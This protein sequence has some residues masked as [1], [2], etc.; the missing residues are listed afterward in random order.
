MKFEPEILKF[1]DGTDVTR[2]N[3]EARRKEMLDILARE[4]YGYTRKKPES[5]KG[6]V[7]NTDNVIASGHAIHETV[8]ISFDTE[9]GE[10][11]F[12][13]N[14]IYPKDKKNSPWF[15]LIN[16]RPDLYDKYYPLEEI[17]D[18]GFAVA[19]IYYNDITT[20]DG[21]FTNGLA[22]M[23]S[24][25]DPD[26]DWGKI[27]MWAFGASRALDYL[28]TREEI[29]KDN[30]AVIGHSRLGKTALWCAAQDERFKFAVSNDSG[31]SGAA[32][33][34]I[35]HGNSETIERITN[36]FPYW[37]CGNFKKYAD[38][39][40]ARPFDQHFLLG[41]ICPRYVLVGS[42]SLDGW[43]DP[44]SE[45]LSCV[46]ADPLWKLLDKKGYIGKEEPAAIGE[47]FFEGDISYHLRD[48]IHFLG[49]QDWQNYMSFVKSKL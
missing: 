30:V 41:S 33:E 5:V 46:A 11:T 18:N 22:G 2:D 35:K 17:I 21:D 6:E 32:Y 37:F 12:P 7:I 48:G 8:N 27:G 24:R 13:L 39:P 36:V 19:V 15:I 26:T 31:C 9:K 20:D 34:R 44:Y 43:A 28:S 29:D 3:W 23:Y 45:Q 47:H 1:C 42:A 4:E 38:K 25:N 10:F 16:F 40:D 14:F 49:R